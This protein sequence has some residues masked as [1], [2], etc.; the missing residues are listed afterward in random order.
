[1]GGKVLW[2]SDS[3]LQASSVRN[4]GGQAVNA[5]RR[6]TKTE[7]EAGPRWITQRR[8]TMSIQKT[9]SST[10]QSIKVGRLGER[11][12]P[13]APPNRSDHRWQ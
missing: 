11:M 9:G 5:S 7:H 4:Q 2:E 10:G 12:S 8:L 1:M 3:I 13:Y 6:R